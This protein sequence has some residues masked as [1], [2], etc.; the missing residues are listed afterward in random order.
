MRV[1]T[2][3]KFLDIKT[4]GEKNSKLMTAYD[5]ANLV[6][7]FLDDEQEMQLAGST[8]GKELTLKIDVYLTKNNQMGTKLIEVIK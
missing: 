2:K 1:I 4:V 7:V 6:K 5:G 8:F 3:V